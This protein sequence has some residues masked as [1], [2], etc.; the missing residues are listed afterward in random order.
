M[1]GKCNGVMTILVNRQPLAFYT[2][3]GANPTNLIVLDNNI[4]IRK[5][6]RVVHE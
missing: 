5:A 6:L 1:S 4:H 3:C 2:H